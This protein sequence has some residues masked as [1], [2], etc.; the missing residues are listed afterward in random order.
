MCYLARPRPG[1]A[2]NYLTVRSFI[3]TLNADKKKKL[4]LLPSTYWN[5]PSIEQ[6]KI[7][8]IVSGQRENNKS[9]SFFAEI[10][11]C[12]AGRV[13]LVCQEERFL[14][15]YGRL[16]TNLP[17]FSLWKSVGNEWYR[18]KALLCYLYGCCW[19]DLSRFRI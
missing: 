13:S 15:P 8:K 9:V 19:F 4:V 1:E 14:P 6:Y 7:M 3:T 16:N 18:W 2:F 12:T 11:L 17:A 10:K 5:F